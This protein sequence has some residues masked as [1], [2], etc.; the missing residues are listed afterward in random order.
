MAAFHEFTLEVV[1]IWKFILECHFITHIIVVSSCDVRQSM[2]LV[3]SEGFGE[4]AGV[5]LLV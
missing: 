4:S 2:I 5:G 1:V 3:R